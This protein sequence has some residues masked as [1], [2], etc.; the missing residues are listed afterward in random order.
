MMFFKWLVSLL[1][2]MT[3]NVDGKPYLTRYYLF[4]KDR[5]FGNVYIH[6]FHSSDQGLELHNHPWVWGVSFVLSGGYAEERARS[7]VTWD[8]TLGPAIP[9]KVMIEKRHIKPCSINVIRATD[10]HR[11]DLDVEEKGA[12]TIFMAGRRA[13]SWG[14]L[15]R[16]TAEYKDWR[17]NPEAIE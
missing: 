10:F 2:H 16:D 5:K 4:L 8:A 9:H 3:I 7:P 11:V 1:P 14:F 17:T 13:K 15:N 6:H 12:W